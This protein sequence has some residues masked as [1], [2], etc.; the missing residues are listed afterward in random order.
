M[1][2]PGAAKSIPSCHRPHRLSVR[3]VPQLAPPRLVLGGGPTLPPFFIKRKEPPAVQPVVLEPVPRVH[4]RRHARPPP[5]VGLGQGRARLGHAQPPMPA[6]LV[7]GDRAVLEQHGLGHVV[8]SQ[9]RLRHQLDDVGAVLLWELGVGRLI[10]ELQ[11][12]LLAAAGV[13]VA[14]G[15][16]AL[17]LLVSL[18]PP[19]LPELHETEV[20]TADGP[21]TP[22]A[23][24]LGSHRR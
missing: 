2:R 14:A 11:V 9:V 8:G 18:A 1:R 6:S 24:R 13:L 22:I 3:E 17:A 20:L 5:Q 23:Q 19:L 12:P 16:P 15:A 21:A 4:A 10:E 7:Q